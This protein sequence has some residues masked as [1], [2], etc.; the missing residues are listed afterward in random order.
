MKKLISALL[1]LLL[2]FAAHAQ[3]AYPLFQPSDGIMVGDVNTYVTTSAAASD[4]ISLW[5][6]TCNA[7][8]FLRGDGSCGVPPGTGVTSVGLSAPS[9]FSVT[10]SPITTSGTLALAFASGQPANQFLATPNGSSG[11]LGLRAI[12][13]G[14]LPLISLTSGVTGTLPVANG[15]TGATTLT[16]VLRGNG[17]SPFTSAASADV[18]SLWSGT[19]NAS[20][21]LRGDGAC[22]S[23]AGGTPAGPNQSVQ[24]NNS[25]AFGGDADLL[26]DSAANT[27]TLATGSAIQPASGGSLAIGQSAGNSSL[28]LR[29]AGGSNLL[30]QTNGTTRL[31]MNAS[32]AWL[33]G[34][35]EGT[36]GQ[37]LTSSGVG[38]APTWAAAGGGGSPGGSDTAVQFNDAGVFGGQSTLFT[39]DKT[40][41][42]VGVGSTAN[43]GIVQ[44]RNNPSTGNGGA[45]RVAGGDGGSNGSG[46]FITV[47]GGAGNGAGNNGGGVIVAGGIPADGNGGSIA[48]SGQ[49][50]V[51][52]SRTGSA[53]SLSG[54]DSTNAV[55]GG[56]ITADAGRG[57]AT[58]NG[59]LLTLTAGQGGTTSG[60]GGL[61]TLRGGSAGANG[62]GGGVAITGRNAAGTAQ[63][64]GSISITAGNGI[65][66]G[67]AGNVTITAGSSPSGTDGSV[68][69]AT[70]AASTRL[71][72]DGTGAW[73]MAGTTPGA[74]TNVLTSNG[75]GAAPTWQAVPAT[76]P[77]GSTTQVQFNNAGA[78]GGDAGMTYNSGTDTLSIGT[79]TA[80]T[81]ITVA[82]QNVC[83]ANGTNCPAAAS[84][85]VCTTS[86]D[87]STL[88]VGNFAT[89]YKTAATSR[90]S[91]TTPADD[92][93]LIFTNAP[94]GATY[95]MDA[96]INWDQNG[97]TTNG[98]TLRPIAGS[99][100]TQNRL[101]T[102]AANTS[103]A[104]ISPQSNGNNPNADLIF[105]ASGGGGTLRVATCNASFTT[106]AAAAS[107]AFQWAQA[108]SVATNT[109]VNAGSW[110]RV[111][112]V[113]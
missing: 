15:G 44:G 72:I 83:Q 103:S 31:T 2:A 32:G 14:D 18:I 5:G 19:C 54:G 24:F 42:M 76:A 89:V 16:G 12:V 26:W 75:A 112:R 28:T 67:A 102:T 105:T 109:D 13:A 106:F 49:S 93:D 45:L 55:A 80:A 71:T 21:F 81:A 65:T 66:S 95:I 85:I 88:T 100:T 25:G 108:A 11:A 64:G 107:F 68:S 9:V 59:G 84:N 8:A 52:T 29:A 23:P 91:T 22:A 10:G 48:L 30:F 1:P 101:C 51:G 6:G 62:A 34:G 96:F 104:N 50:G 60:D 74:A 79:V 58:G 69:I 78:F 38:A 61:A 33:I 56:A 36:A 113:Q 98:I 27:L 92:P 39:F 57:G 35:T 94:N 90:N 73:L 40:T 47:R 99:V 86:C 111:Q 37:V 87:I 41:N 82:G 63:V 17:T 53:I 97:A 46:G 43:T 70:N 20:S 7:S 110:Y 4:V 3:T 77:G